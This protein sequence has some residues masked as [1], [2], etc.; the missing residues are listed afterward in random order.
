MK[1][2]NNP[3]R[4]EWAALCQRPVQDD[5]AIT[6]VVENIMQQV[7]S[8][9]DKALLQLSQDIDGVQLTTLQVTEE[10]WTAALDSVDETF[11][12]AVQLAYENI[13]AFHRQQLPVDYEVSPMPGIRCSR[14]W[15]PMQRVGLYI[16][17]GS[18]P[19]CSTVFMLAIPAGIAGCEDVIL[20]TPPDAKG[21]VNAA[22]L[23]VAKLC[24]VKAVYKTGGAQAIA[25]MTYGTET[26]GRV[27]KL[28]GPGNQ[29]VTKAKQ[30]ATLEGMPIDMP[31]GPSEV[32][33]VA[34]ERA[35]PVFVAADLLSQAEHGADSQV[36]LLT[37]SVAMVQ[38]VKAEVN[39]Q[40]DQLPRKQ[41]AAQAM[42]NSLAIMFDNQTDLVAFMN[43]YAPEHLILAT[44]QPELLAKEVRNAGSVFLGDYT[45]EAAGDYASGTNHTLPTNGAA[46]SWSGLGVESFMKSITF[47]SLTQQGVEAIGPA[48]MRLAEAEELEAHRYAMDI[49]LSTIKNNSYAIL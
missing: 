41:L 48:V 21:S 9:G 23:Y 45:P 34:D 2:Y 43:A 24:G 30:L 11:K 3:P 6:P 1:Q 17:G 26:I 44:A 12:V 36:V 7:K 27:N 31:A 10:E 19:L 39:Q 35:N 47:Q 29:Y 5:S 49:R 46:R 37:N 4:S 20:C 33:L 13:S 32:M 42:S 25:A 22:I 18:A 8:G 38:A 16:P 28:F 15:L 40:L 14:K